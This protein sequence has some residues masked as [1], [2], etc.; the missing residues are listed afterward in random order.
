MYSTRHLRRLV[1]KEQDKLH[2]KLRI[3]EVE[4]SLA[5]ENQPSPMIDEED[6]AYD[7]LDMLEFESYDLED[8]KTKISL[9]EKLKH[10]GIKHNISQE[11]AR[12]LVK[13]LKEENIKIVDT[14]SKADD[15]SPPRKMLK[16]NEQNGNRNFK[17]EGCCGCEQRIAKL[18]EIMKR[19]LGVI[20]QAIGEQ[21]VML[22][23]LF[24]DRVCNQTMS[25][26]FPITTAEELIELDE[27][28]QNG[29]KDSYVELFK[30][31]LRPNG[32][33]KNIRYIIS[34][35]LISDYNVDGVSGKKALKSHEH[36][37]QALIGAIPFDNDGTPEDQLRRAFQ[38]AKKRIAKR[39]SQQLTMD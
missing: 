23:R 8:T 7:P 36:F 28:I 20:A 2:E 21:K 12:D 35:E 33:I 16:R 9:S 37:Y 14:K 11:C 34:D 25:Q 5:S 30:S 10:W 18:E 17:P 13:I 22:S 24:N 38:L 15:S 31:M 27:E 26:N 3:A 19:Q 39:K 1:K 6:E 29:E 4:A 32:I